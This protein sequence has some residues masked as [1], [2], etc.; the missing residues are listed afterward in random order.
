[1]SSRSCLL[2]CVLSD[3]AGDKTQPLMTYVNKWLWL[4]VVSCAAK[5]YVSPAGLAFWPFPSNF[6]FSLQAFGV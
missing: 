5:K 4:I 3:V 6:G 2:F 1:M